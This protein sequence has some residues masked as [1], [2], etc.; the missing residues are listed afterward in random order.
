MVRRPHGFLTPATAGFG[1]DAIRLIIATRVALYREGLAEALH[2]KARIAV[3]GTAAS[4]TELMA[5]VLD[6]ATDAVLL[7]TELDGAIAT[8]SHLL[9]RRPDLKIV[10]LGAFTD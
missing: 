9:A 3:V 7:D 1:R 5:S 10:A 6:V 4:S 8:A 2:A